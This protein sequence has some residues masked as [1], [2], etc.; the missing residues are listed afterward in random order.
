[1]ANK[2]HQYHRT[3]K[4]CCWSDASHSGPAFHHRHL[5]TSRLVAWAG[6]TPICDDLQATPAV[7]HWVLHPKNLPFVSQFGNKKASTGRWHT[8]YCKSVEQ[9][10]SN[11]NDTQTIVRPSPSPR[12][13]NRSCGMMICLVPLCASASRGRQ[14]QQGG[15]GG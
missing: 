1:M 2:K 8:Y 10:T 5:Q 14:R 11:P 15:R 9:K 6:L 3:Q 7:Q 13:L 12:L 4:G